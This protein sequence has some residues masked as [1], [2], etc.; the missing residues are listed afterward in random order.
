MAGSSNLTVRG[1]TPAATGVRASLLIEEG[2]MFT[3]ART[4][5]SWRSASLLFREL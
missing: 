2:R 4:R 1:G 3:L 5:S